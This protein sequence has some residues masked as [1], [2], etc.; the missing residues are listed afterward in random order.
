VFTLGLQSLNVNQGHYLAAAVTSLGIGTGHIA[1]YK[2]MPGA[3]RARV[4]GYSSAAS[5]ASPRA[6]GSTARAK[7]WIS[8]RVARW[9]ARRAP[10]STP[11]SGTA[12]A[13]QRRP[14]GPRNTDT[15]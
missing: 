10:T 1:L 12:A 8:L 9:K 14:G 15:H 7:A 11:T 2:Y 13:L 5:P 3:G 6:C 4:A